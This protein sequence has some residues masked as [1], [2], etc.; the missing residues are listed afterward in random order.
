[1]P[2]AISYTF[3]IL[4]RNAERVLMGSFVVARHTGQDQLVIGRAAVAAARMAE[5]GTAPAKFWILEQAD[6]V[7][8][9]RVEWKE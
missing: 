4:L 9:G 3:W 6:I 5:E 1:M 2:L 8:L 7:R